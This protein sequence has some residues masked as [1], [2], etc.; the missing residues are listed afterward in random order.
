ME[1]LPTVDTW[2]LKVLLR[3]DFGARA[4]TVMV[5]GPFWGRNHRFPNS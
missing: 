2:A 4:R 1:A 5:P 3:H